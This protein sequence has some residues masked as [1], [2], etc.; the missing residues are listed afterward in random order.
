MLTSAKTIADL[1]SRGA[2]ELSDRELVLYEDGTAWTWRQAFEEA[3]R[4]ANVLSGHGVRRDGRVMMLLPNGSGWLRTWWGTTL[5]GGVFA[6]VNPAYQGKL[7]A[8]VCDLIDP[9]VIVAHGDCAQRL[10]G[11]YRDIVI[12]PEEL[13]QGAPEVDPLNPPAE[14]WDTHCLVM[15][16]GTTGASKA[17]ISTHRYLLHHC[18]FLVDGANI[19]A[20]DIFQADMPWFHLTG[21][22][23][24][25]QMMRV[26]GKIALRTVPAMTDYWRTAKKIG[27]TFALAPGTVA[28]YLDTQ[29]ESDADRDHSIRFLL[30]SPL[31]ADPQR[32][33]A[34]FGLDG[35]FTA[36]GSTEAN[37]VVVNPLDVPLRRNSCGKAR[38][39]YEIRI[40]DEHDQEVPVGEVGELIV[41]AQEPWVQFQGYLN[42]PAATLSA[43]RNGW[44]HS[45]DALR[46]DA[47]GYYYFHDRYKDSLRRR[48]ENISSHDVET[49]V[50]EFPG[51][52]EVAC[53]AHPGEY[54]GDDEVK[55]YIVSAPGTDIDFPGLLT[56]L[57]KRM[58]YF[59][60]PRYYELLDELPKTP[61]QRVQKH[62]LRRR[63]NTKY[64]WDLV[65]EGYRV[66]RNGLEYPK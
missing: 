43:W 19:N 8:D 13:T 25:V 33:M 51:V 59:M 53:V 36:Y 28:Q 41:R 60:V 29:P 20:D 61:T 63:G 32:F 27:S 7:L 3:A 9:A 2:V 46:M 38:R 54:G 26:G 65:T 34:R 37:I 44:F 21:V 30:S 45:G 16:S 62:E 39:G 50:R 14:P 10:E 15:T 5:L 35:L 24:A 52:A 47:D 1:L 49:A 18:D 6:S 22:A 64:T 55:I 12:D 48:G 58:A 23:P 57:V 17:S 4:A 42:N 40:V 11:R 66:T 31:P 56:F